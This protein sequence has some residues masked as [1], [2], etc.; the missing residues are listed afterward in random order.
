MILYYGAD[1]KVIVPEYLKGSPNN[2]YGLGFYMTSEYDKAK[3]WASKFSGG[4]YLIKYEVDLNDLEIL[5]INDS[6]EESILKWVTLLIRHRFDSR[7]REIYKSTIEFLQN[8]FAINLDF[9]DFI[10]GYRADDSY[11]SYMNSFVKNELSFELL[12]KAMKLGHLG[13]QYVAISKKAFSKIK[14]I[15]MEYIEHSNE[16]SK[17]QRKIQQ[18]YRVLKQEDKITNTF[19]RDIMRKYEKDL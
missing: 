17:F 19:I 18:Q 2:D 5:H 14:F 9:V 3:I 15:S 6:N 13:L 12:T 4:G 8:H 7:T 16:Y 10:I 11:F 1:S